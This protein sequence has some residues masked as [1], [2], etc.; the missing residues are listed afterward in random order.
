MNNE[1]LYA[2]AY[3][4][5]GMFKILIHCGGHHAVFIT[6]FLDKFSGLCIVGS[7]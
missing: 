5:V 2:Q 4:H 3:K 6:Q 1:W 7:N